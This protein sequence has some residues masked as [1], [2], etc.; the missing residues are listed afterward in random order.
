MTKIKIGIVAVILLMSNLVFAQ[1]LDDARKL[2]DYQRYGTA[3]ETL[4]KMYAANQ[5]NVDGTGLS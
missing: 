5:G 4:E 3:V 1:T 2:I